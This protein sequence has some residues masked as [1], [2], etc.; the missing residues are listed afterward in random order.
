MNKKADTVF[1]FLRQNRR[2][3]ITLNDLREGFQ[4]F[5]REESI[6]DYIVN[7]VCPC[8][9]SRFGIPLN[10]KSAGTAPEG[11]AGQHP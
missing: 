3:E 7:D 8:I 10:A 9:E 11:E 4:K 1:E 6:R 5:L 2:A